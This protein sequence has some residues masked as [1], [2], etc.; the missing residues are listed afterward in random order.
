MFLKLLSIE[1]TRLWRR[2]LPW[3]TLVIVALYIGLSLSNFYTTNQ[4]E[5]LNGSLKMPGVSFDLANS[6]DQL[7]I[8]IPFLVIIAGNMMGNDYT[9]RTT[10]TG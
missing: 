6:L 2:A 7:L 8:A 10:S 5:L 1:W 9:Q 3:V 4:P